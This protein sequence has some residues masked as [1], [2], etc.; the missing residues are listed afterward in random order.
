M[1]DYKKNKSIAVAKKIYNTY[2]S[3]NCRSPINIEGST[4]DDIIKNISERKFSENMF[5]VARD[6]IYLLIAID[7]YARYINSEYFKTFSD[8]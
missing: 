6:Q 1:N 2:I 3:P 8:V 5:D 7:S 4:R